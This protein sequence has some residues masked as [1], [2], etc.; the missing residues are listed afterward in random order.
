MEAVR[1]RVRSGAGE[2][3]N[4]APVLEARLADAMARLVRDDALRAGLSAASA[5]LCDGL[6]ATRAAEGLLSILPH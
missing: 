6:G 2:L 5:A 4:A 1:A 3:Q